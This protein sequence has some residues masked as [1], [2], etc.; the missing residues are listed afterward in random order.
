MVQ[1]HS[2]LE[3]FTLTTTVPPAELDHNV[4]GLTVTA[5]APGSERCPIY[6][7]LPAT[8]TI[9][10]RVAPVLFEPAEIVTEPAPER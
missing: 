9:R 2:G 4:V 3:D 10:A 1:E 8:F 6:M 7:S 5:H